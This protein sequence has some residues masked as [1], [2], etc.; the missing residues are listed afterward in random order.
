MAEITLGTQNHILHEAKGI[1]K[2]F[3]LGIKEIIMQFMRSVFHTVAITNEWVEIFDSTESLAGVKEVGEF[4]TFPSAVLQEGFQITLEPRQYAGSLL[5][6][7]KQ[8]KKMGD[9][10]ILVQQFLTRQ[11]NALLKNIRY[12]LVTSAF[13]PYNDAFTKDSYIGPDGEA[14]ISTT[15]K[16]K[17]DGSWSNLFTAAKLDEGPVDTVREE[18]AKF[19]DEKGQKD[20]RDYNWIMVKKGTKTAKKAQQLF[21]EGISPIAFQDTNIY[22]GRFNIFETPYMDNVDEW[23]MFDD[24]FLESPVYVKIN[25]MPTMH[26][27]QIEKNLAVYTPVTGFW[28]T[29]INFLPTYLTG[30]P[31]TG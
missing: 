26:E 18:G 7:Y 29:G 3:D 23:F 15:H 17:G 28:E 13:G 20:P 22:L 10:T 25:E 4:E 27:S 6:S 30:S 14:M 1:K 24:R 31:G 16:W 11:R 5:V 8:Q 9:N 21:A 12:Q 2:S 19:V